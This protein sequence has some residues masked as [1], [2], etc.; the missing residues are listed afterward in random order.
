MLFSRK[1]QLI[2]SQ[3]SSTFR[4]NYSVSESTYRIEVITKTSHPMRGTCKTQGKCQELHLGQGSIDAAFSDQV[5][6]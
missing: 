2:T 1:R 6:A 4:R 3:T 5:S